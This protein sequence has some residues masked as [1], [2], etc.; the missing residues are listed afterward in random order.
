MRHPVL[1]SIAALAIAALALPAS[2]PAQPA[3]P[4]PQALVRR[5]V[6]AAGGEQALRSI[7]NTSIDFYT[8]LFQLGQE[9][10]PESPPRP[11]IATGRIVTDWANGRRFAMQE[12]RGGPQAIRTRGVNV[13]DVGMGTNQAGAQTPQQAANVAAIRRGMRLSA[14]RL[15][16]LAHDNPAAL[17]RLPARTIRGDAADGARFALGPDTLSMWFDRASGLLLASETV[18]DDGVLGDRRDLTIYQRWQPAGNTGALLPRQQDQLANGR[19]Q[20]SLSITGLTVNDALPDSL[21]VIPDSIRARAPQ[22]GA[23]APPVVVTLNELAPGVWRAEGGSHFSLVVEQPAGLVLVEA[24]LNAARTRAVLDTL[25]ARF[26]SKRVTQVVATHHHWDHSGG[27]RAAMAEGIPIV[28]QRRLDGFLRGIASA[29]KTRA[30]DALA[31]TRRVP[32]IRL[33]DDSLTLG[34][35]DSRVVIHRM[36][37]T[38]AEGLVAAFVPAHGILFTSD[39]LSPGPQLPPL[40]VREVVDFARARGLRVTRFAGGHG[41]V[42]PWGELEGAYPR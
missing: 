10:T 6:Q 13:G 38:H 3:A 33:L 35:G 17:S 14:H 4:A 36:P 22:P 12:Q 32:T 25:R 2:L 31:R 26:P 40:G 5:A 34:T 42:A 19:L 7:Q 15:L 20:Q 21:F 8:A 18:T 16:L 30:P 1:L 29:P 39:V 24:P 23:A 11:G 28:A 9:E 37:T 41:G 27:L